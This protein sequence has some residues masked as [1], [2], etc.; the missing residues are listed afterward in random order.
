MPKLTRAQRVAAA[1]AIDA[2]WKGSKPDPLAHTQRRRNAWAVV[3]NG[4]DFHPH[5]RAVDR[6]FVKGLR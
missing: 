4:R 2:K 1:K 5:T 6:H 3:P